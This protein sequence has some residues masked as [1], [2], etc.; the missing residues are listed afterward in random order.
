MFED[1]IKQ[2]AVDA[3]IRDLYSDIVTYQNE[4]K[5]YDYDDQTRRTNREE[6]R[7]LDA[8]IEIC[9]NVIKRL[10]ALSEG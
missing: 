8:K 6:L 2:S 4:M 9:R 1:T 5:P 7:V 3:L 10:Q